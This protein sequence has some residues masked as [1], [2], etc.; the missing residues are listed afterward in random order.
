MITWRLLLLKGLRKGPVVSVDAF[1][2][3]NNSSFFTFLPR[4]ELVW[5]HC[6]RDF[7]IIDGQVWNLWRFEV[8]DANKGSNYNSKEQHNDNYA[9]KDAKQDGGWLIALKL[10]ELALETGWTDALGAAL[11]QLTA[12][13][14]GDFNLALLTGETSGTLA[15]DD[16]LGEEGVDVEDVGRHGVLDTVELAL[17]VVLAESAAAARVRPLVAPPAEVA[18]VALAGVGLGAAGP[19]LAEGAHGAVVA[20]VPGLA[21]ALAGS[22][23]STVGLAQRVTN[24]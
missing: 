22:Y 15:A 6:W 11:V 24:G 16:V 23:T 19:V 21:S 5:G 17:A 4:W 7:E 9:D 13:L 3:S 18:D 20:T 14:A 8:G 2:L 1:L 10:A 12:I